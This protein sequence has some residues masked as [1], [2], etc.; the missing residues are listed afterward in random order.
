MASLSMASRARV[1]SVTAW[2]PPRSLGTSTVRTALC[3]GRSGLPGSRRRPPARVVVVRAKGEEDQP[4]FVT[5]MIGKL[6][7]SAMEDMAPAGLTRMTVE[8]WP[9]QWPAVVD[10]WAE[11]FDG[12][13]EAMAAIRPVLKQTM[14]ESVP[15]GLA[16]DANVHGW[17]TSAFH[18]QLDG[19]GAAVLVG[20][21][22]GGAVFGA[23]NP[24]GWLGYGDWR[25]AIS[26]FLFVWPDGDM[27]V[28]P[29]KM[30]KCGGSGMAIIDE[31]GKGPQWGPDGLK[32]NITNKAAISRLGPY[33]DVRPDGSKFLFTADEGKSADLVALQV[34]VGLEETEKAKNYEPNALQWQPGELEKIRESDE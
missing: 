21:T 15:L 3:S 27:S 28:P 33:Y 2:S 17:S 18:T 20:E 30:A 23:Y 32:V 22:T 5:R 10:E 12:D 14:L 8:E 7:P 9:D 34:Y 11:S 6:F 26:A 16:Y 25:D 24:K 13:D 1:A 31:P 29:Q 4:D 19:M